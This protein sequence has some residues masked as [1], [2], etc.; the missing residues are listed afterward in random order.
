MSRL[1]FEQA[2]ARYVHR[3]TMQHVPQWSTKMCGNGKYYAPQF[4]TDEQWYAATKFPGEPGLHRNCKYCIT[5]EP[6][7]PLG[8]WLDSPFIKEI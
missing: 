2:R 3:Y 8:Q 6:T 7:W 1:T 5:G 4:E